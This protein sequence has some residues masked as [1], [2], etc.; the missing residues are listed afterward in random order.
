VIE[1]DEW[2]VLGR[3]IGVASGWDQ[4]DTFVMALYDFEPT[5]GIKLPSGTLTI[6]FE[7]GTASTYDDAG[8]VLE[9]VD[10]VKAIADAPWT[11]VESRT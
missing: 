3:T 11:E 1:R 10:L 7:A 2:K 8:K 6:D 5:D 9:S 4:A